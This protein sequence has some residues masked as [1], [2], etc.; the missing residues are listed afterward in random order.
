MP[1][2]TPKNLVTIIRRAFDATMKDKAFLA[3][4]E[5]THLEVDPLTGEQMQKNIVEAYQADK[6]TIDRMSELMGRQTKG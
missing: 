4:A 1:P 6:A 5:K 3:E 2:G